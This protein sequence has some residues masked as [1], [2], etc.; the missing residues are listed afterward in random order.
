M[1]P[2]PIPLVVG[3]L[4]GLVKAAAAAVGTDDDPIRVDLGDPGGFS[5]WRAIGVGLSAVQTGPVED[6]D[7]RRTLGKD[8]HAFDVACVA[9]AW[10][11]DLDD[12]LPWMSAA[13][14]LVDI[15]RDVLADDVHL[16]LTGVI[17]TAHVASTSF[18]WVEDRVGEKALVDFTVRVNAYRSRR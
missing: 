5:E 12:K 6:R 16:G 11:G 1:A 7:I 13:F 4:H 15:V 17:Q 14:D 9:L 3:A 2:H 8:L 10:S 18:S